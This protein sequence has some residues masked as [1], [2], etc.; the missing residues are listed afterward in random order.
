MQHLAVGSLKV[1]GGLALGEEAVL[2]RPVV[3]GVVL[4]Q[5]LAPEGAEL[6]GGV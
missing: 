1:D 3:R 2:D 6:G 4:D 5:V